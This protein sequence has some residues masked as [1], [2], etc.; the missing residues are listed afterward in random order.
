M[1]VLGIDPGLANTG[2]GFVNYKK[3]KITLVDYGNIVT[4]K[5]DTFT[6]RLKKINYEINKLIDK[7]NPQEV[8]IED[9]FFNKNTKTALLVSKVH[10]AIAL[11]VSLIGLELYEYTPLQVK[12]ATVGN[13]R[14]DKYQVQSMVKILL[15]LQKIPRPDHASDALAV[16][17]CHVHTKY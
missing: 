15:N 1:I 16:A 2:Y 9:I 5:E 3:K 13:G 10:G 14:A 11:S 7:Y 6:S 12:Q 4:K 17:I 8:A